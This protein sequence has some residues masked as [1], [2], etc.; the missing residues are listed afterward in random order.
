MTGGPMALSL[1]GQIYRLEDKQWLVDQN[2]KKLTD[3]D[4]MASVGPGKLAVIRVPE[5]QPIPDDNPKPIPAAPP[6]AKA[7]DETKEIPAPP[8][9]EFFKEPLPPGRKIV[10][11]KVQVAKA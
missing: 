1:R 9:Q 8:K 10:V 7:D 6:A 11:P 5:G 2:G 4:F 3:P